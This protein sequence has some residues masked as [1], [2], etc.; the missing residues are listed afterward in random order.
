[1]AKF[2]SER[3]REF[4]AQTYDATVSDWPGELEFYRQLSAARSKGRPV[5]EVACGTGRV[6]T[7]LA[8]DGI[9]VVGLDLS[10][11][12]LSVARTKSAGLGNI[13]WVEADMRSFDLDQTFHLAILPGHSFQ[14]L[15][16]EDD[17]VSTLR[18]VHRHLLPGGSL[19]V[20]LDHPDPAWLVQIAGAQGGLFK[21]AGSFSHPITGRPIRTRQAWSYE[22]ATRTA[23][24][25]TIWEAVDA[26]DEVVEHWDSGP[27]RLRSVARDEMQ[28]L[29]ERTGYRVE[30]VYGD[31]HR[32]PLRDDSEDMI[33]VATTSTLQE[34]RS[35]LEGAP[36]GHGARDG[37]VAGGYGTI[38]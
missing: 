36:A 16:T 23:V 5:L 10:P 4:Y 25:Q 38:S 3:A 32:N 14:N 12:M 6:A 37:H 15:I 20:H 22:P 30:E 8:Q 18:S 7:R 31:F 9:S 34:A 11:A 19:V 24:S 35:F 27:L 26:G 1:M 33:W 13:R 21:E 2:S 17:Q 29:L 28:A